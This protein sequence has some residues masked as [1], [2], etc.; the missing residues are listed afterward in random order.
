MKRNLPRVNMNAISMDKPH[1]CHF[2]GKQFGR[3]YSLKRHIEN[4]HAEEAEYVMR[5]QIDGDANSNNSDQDHY[6]PSFKKIKVCSKGEDHETTESEEEVDET[7][8]SDNFDSEK[9]EENEHLSD[10]DEQPSSELEDN[11]HLSDED[12]ESSS[13][14]EDN[15]HSSDEDEESSSELEDNKRLSDEDEESSSELEDNV[16]YRDWLDEAKEATD[17]QWNIKYEKY[18]NEGMNEDQAKEKA[19]RKIRWAFKR[20]FFDKYMDFLLS[21]LHLKDDETHREVLEDIE[22]RVDKGMDVHKAL[23]RVIPRHQAKFKGLFHLE[24]DK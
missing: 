16:A 7:S 19:D 17:E 3:R 24:E 22:E 18:T 12:E 10:E 9:E 14:L 11:K 4:A 23:N 1:L 8:R 15:E 21:Y 13:E 5:N 20:I 2:C 6:E